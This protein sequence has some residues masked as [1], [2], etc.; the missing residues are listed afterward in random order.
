MSLVKNVMFRSDI[1]KSQWHELGA[2]TEVEVEEEEEKGMRTPK[3][4][5]SASSSSAAPKKPK[6]KRKIEIVEEPETD[7]GSELDEE[8]MGE[9]VEEDDGTVDEAFKELDRL[10]EEEEE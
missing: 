8:S 10:L 9:G 5:P 7:L 1:P 3:R 6:K 4:K 2:E